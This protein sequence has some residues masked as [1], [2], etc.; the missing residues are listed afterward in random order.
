MDCVVAKGIVIDCCVYVSVVWTLRWPP[1]VV[2]KCVVVTEVVDS[3]VIN[4]DDR[5]LDGD[6][7]ID[8][9]DVIE[10]LVLSFPY[11]NI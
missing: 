2:D 6:V 11:I 10:A 9:V 1:S 4:V 7:L 8:E 5:S 3:I